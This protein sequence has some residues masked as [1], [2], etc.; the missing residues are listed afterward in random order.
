MRCRV[1]LGLV[2]TAAVL[3]GCGGE[4]PK[5][6]AEPTESAASTEPETFTVEGEMELWDGGLPLRDKGKCHGMEG[7]DDI[8]GVAQVIVRNG[9]G[10][11]LAIGAL[12][13][14]MLQDYGVCLFDFEVPGV[15]PGEK[16]YSVEVSHRG[17]ITYD[18]SD[19]TSPIFLT[20]GD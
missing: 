8:R 5:A 20:L 14:G 19:I 9:D 10:K 7:Y 15:P 1:A 18:E 6:T 2:V 16:F 11:T 13:Q 17:E 12:E 3:V 4:E